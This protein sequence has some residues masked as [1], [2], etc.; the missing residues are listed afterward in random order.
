M[1]VRLWFT[2]GALVAVGFLFSSCQTVEEGDGRESDVISAPEAP[3]KSPAELH[4]EVLRG[5][6]DL[7]L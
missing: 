3:Y 5:H 1:N 4:R 7:G 6:R 2:L